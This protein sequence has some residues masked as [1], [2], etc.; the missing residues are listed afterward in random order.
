MSIKFSFEEGNQ[1]T[2]IF[3]TPSLKI[4]DAIKLIA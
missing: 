2:E 4:N 1:K 3:G